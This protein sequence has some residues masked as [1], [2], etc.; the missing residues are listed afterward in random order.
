MESIDITKELAALSKD[1]QKSTYSGVTL[2]RAGAR[3]KTVEVEF[4]QKC[5]LKVFEEAKPTEG[6]EIKLSQ[7]DIRE[8]LF[9]G[10]TFSINDNSN[11]DIKWIKDAKNKDYEYRNSKATV[12]NLAWAKKAEIFRLSLIKA[13]DA[14]ADTK[15]LKA[16]VFT[17][18]DIYRTSACRNIMVPLAYEVLEVSPKMRNLIHKH[19]FIQ[20]VSLSIFAKIYLTSNVLILRTYH[21]VASLLKAK[22]EFWELKEGSS[23]E[24]LI[25][26][27]FSSVAVKN[28]TTIPNTRVDMESFVTYGMDIEST[29]FLEASHFK[30]NDITDEN[31][32]LAEAQVCKAI[33]TVHKLA[34]TALGDETIKS[35]HTLN[36]LQNDKTG[37]LYVNRRIYCMKKSI[38]G[39]VLPSS[40]GGIKKKYVAVSSSVYTPYQEKF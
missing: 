40:S 14:L 35:D 22:G 21:A 17:W 13:R 8:L 16:Y 30:R 27:A 11:E 23:K 12:G 38:T 26:L 5:L 37:L 28:F 25:A 9:Y 39:I 1:A 33:N 7:D 36:T 20:A 34:A 31:K 32:K 2:F 6:K 10:Q 19:G 3:D 29:R 24:D 4:A 15:D 18:G